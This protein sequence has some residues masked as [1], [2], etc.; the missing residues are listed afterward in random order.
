MTAFFGVADM[1]RRTSVPR[2]ST[3]AKLLDTPPSGLSGYLDFQEFAVA[4]N[5][6]MIVVI[7]NL[8]HG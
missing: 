6:V 7:E 2:A 4:T 1:L 3:V 5:M 8:S